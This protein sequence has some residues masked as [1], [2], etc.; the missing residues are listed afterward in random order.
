[1][2]VQN[3]S[4]LYDKAHSI[5]FYN[6]RYEQ[7]YMEE[8]PIE[9]KRRVFE[10]IQALQLPD[11]GEALDFGCGNGVLTEIIRQALPTWTIYG[12]DISEV[13]I[14]NAAKYHPSCVFFK[15]S[16]PSFIDKK[17]DFVF[18]NHVIEHVFN[19]TEVI[20]EISQYLK[21]KASM[22]HFLPCGNEGSYENSICLLR[23]DGINPEMGNRFFFE[24]KGHVRRLTTC[25]LSKICQAQN[26]RLEKAFYANQYYGAI[27][28]ITG[29]GPQFVLNFADPVHAVNLDAKRKLQRTRLYLLTITLLRM[30]TQIF[31]RFLYKK[32]KSLKHFI[33]LGLG[34]ICL[35]FSQPVDQY[36][37]KKAREEW[38]AQSADQRGSEMCLYFTRGY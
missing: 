27:E 38:E 29:S 15:A 6:S 34:L 8:W 31:T 11:K 30:P 33:G 28:W 10:V 17:F 20:H 16:D 4:Q 22:L 3:P 1:M 37:R 19:L 9:K 24:D 21:L 26:F 14:R 36:W 18:T 7:G 35:P 25:Q 32:D 12:T 13:A 2:N 5:E 23:K